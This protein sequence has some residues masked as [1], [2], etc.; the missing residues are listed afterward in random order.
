MGGAGVPETIAHEQKGPLESPTT[1]HNH[2]WAKQTSIFGFLHA[3]VRMPEPMEAHAS[4]TN[5]LK[6]ILR[7]RACKNA[8]HTRGNANESISSEPGK[9]S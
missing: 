6:D 5:E 7:C 8:T 9:S 1:L 3:A 4:I 2:F